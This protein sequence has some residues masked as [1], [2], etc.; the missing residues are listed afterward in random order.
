MESA[1]T[2]KEL[3][4][5][6]KT[7]LCNNFKGEKT[8]KTKQEIILPQKSEQYSIR[9]VCQLAAVAA[10]RNFIL[11]TAKDPDRERISVCWSGDSLPT[12][13]AV[14]F[15]AFPDFDWL[16]TEELFIVFEKKQAGAVLHQLS[17]YPRFQY[18][19]GMETAFVH[20]TISRILLW[21]AALHRVN[22]IISPYPFDQEILLKMRPDEKLS[23][24]LLDLK[25][26]FPEI[27]QEIT[28]DEI[29][30]N[31]QQNRS[32]ENNFAEYA[33]VLW[34]EGDDTI[35]TTG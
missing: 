11:F 26:L 14:A 16:W 33:E 6:C 8:M 35:P 3:K 20:T 24:F 27:K 1:P 22:L 25:N 7:A 34:N 15:L 28:N 31:G 29:R 18:H 32:R 10:K 2:N 30:L 19:D 13:I 17:V 12:K 9:E 5:Y 23:L 4:N 21:M